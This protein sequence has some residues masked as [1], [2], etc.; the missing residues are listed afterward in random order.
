[1]TT[2]EDLRGMSD[3]DTQ[4]SNLL[5]D[6][7]DLIGRDR[8][9]ELDADGVDDVLAAGVPVALRTHLDLMS[10]GGSERARMWVADR[11]LDRAGYSPIKKVAVAEKIT[12][13]PETLKA[14]QMIAKEAETTDEHSGVCAQPLE[15]LGGGLGEDTGGPE[16]AIEAELIFSGE[17]GSGVSGS[18]AS[19]PSGDVQLRARPDHPEKA[20]GASEGAPQD[21]GLHENKTGLEADPEAGSGS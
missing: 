16:G 11:W 13:D 20:G 2:P 18:D 9:P 7:L 10:A 12:I 1:M 17:S 5:A 19:L 15:S 14:L 6:L 21:D 8:L 4:P 3:N